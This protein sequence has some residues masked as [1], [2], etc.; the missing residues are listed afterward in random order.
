MDW[1]FYTIWA[2]AGA[3]LIFVITVLCKYREQLK[4]EKFRDAGFKYQLIY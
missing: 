3:Y 1:P 2:M 4:H